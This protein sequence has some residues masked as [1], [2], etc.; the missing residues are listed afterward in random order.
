MGD[1][2]SFMWT[3]AAGCVY[4]RV[5][6]HGA[7]CVMAEHPQPGWLLC[8]LSFWQVWGT[9]CLTIVVAAGLL[10]ALVG[11]ARPSLGMLPPGQM[12]VAGVG[13]S[14]P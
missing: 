6:L 3:L 9:C 10:Q 1:G 7:G 11:R 13:A 5:G 14:P 2:P 8:C 4:A 12:V